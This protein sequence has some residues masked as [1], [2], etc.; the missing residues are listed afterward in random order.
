MATITL[1]D[2]DVRLR[3]AVVK[4]LDWDPEVDASGIGVAAKDG[5]VTLTGGVPTY[6]DKLAAERVA[7]SVR[8][9][10]GIANDLEVRLKV[11][12]TDAEIAAEAVRALQLRHNVPPEV[13]VAVHDGHVTLT[14]A[15]TWLFQRQQ[16]E[17]AVRHIKGVRGVFNHITVR[18]VSTAKDVRHRIV[19]AL[20]RSA[21]LDARHIDVA[22]EGNVATL[23]GSVS[24]YTQYETAVRACSAAPGITRVDNRLQ[25]GVPE[26]VW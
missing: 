21:D 7:K 25:I 5:V 6:A 14:G 1:T 4:Q 26:E 17:K 9:V 8:G 20:H 16:A 23:K 18:A 24:S 12:F 2:T 10:R 19:E 3:N 15:V 13:Q 11:E 22:V